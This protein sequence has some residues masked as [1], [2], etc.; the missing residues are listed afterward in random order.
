MDKVFVAKGVADQLVASERAI[1]A[2][3]IETGQLTAKMLTAR[4][5]MN[6]GATV[7]SEELAKVATATQAL[8]QARVAMAEAHAGL[9]EVRLRVGIR[10][11]LNGAYKTSSRIEDDVRSIAAA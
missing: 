5:E 3:L 2:A 6:L 11:K 10:T 8:E 9:D 4:H 1:E 7:G